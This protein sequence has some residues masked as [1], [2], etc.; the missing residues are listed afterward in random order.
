MSYLLTGRVDS[1]EVR[2]V[3]FAD[4]YDWFA[5]RVDLDIV[6]IRTV[7]MDTESILRF[8]IYIN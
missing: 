8:L 2:R 3:R 6:E 4:R 1:I 7:Y 5:R